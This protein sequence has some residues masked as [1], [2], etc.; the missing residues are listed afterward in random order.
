MVLCRSCHEIV[1]RYED[2]IR[3]IMEN[4]GASEKD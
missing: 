2:E 4:L 3:K 1:T